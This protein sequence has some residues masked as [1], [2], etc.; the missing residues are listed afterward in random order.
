MAAKGTF[1]LLWEA[2]FIKTY[3][4]K[5][6]CIFFPVT[7]LMIKVQ[8]NKTCVSIKTTIKIYFPLLWELRF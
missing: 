4:F 8:S 2:Q 5:T 1:W 6:F 3:I 7:A